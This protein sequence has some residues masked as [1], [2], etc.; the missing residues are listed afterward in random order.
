MTLRVHLS[1]RRLQRR[2]LKVV[3]QTKLQYYEDHEITGRPP[4]PGKPFGLWY[5]CGTGKEW[6]AWLRSADPKGR[7]GPRGKYAYVL[8][9]DTSRLLTIDTRARFAEFNKVARKTGVDLDRA[10]SYEPDWEAV[11]KVYGGVEICPYRHEFRTKVF[12]YYGWDVAS[13]CI[14]DPEIIRGMEEMTYK[15]FAR[16]AR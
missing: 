10:I 9:V 11:A 16:R 5:A 3:P 2:Y 14:W 6:L 12:W 13:G 15:D 8:D 4:A 1:E 7:L